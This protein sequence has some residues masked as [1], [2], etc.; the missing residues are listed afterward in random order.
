[1]ISLHEG[2][3]VTFFI[4]KKV[5]MV[6]PT[7]LIQVLQLTNQNLVAQK[8]RLFSSSFAWFPYLLARLFAFQVLFLEVDSTHESCHCVKQI[9]LAARTVLS[10][11]VVPIRSDFSR[12]ART[13]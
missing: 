7:F 3:R 10:D 8:T 5:T 9:C 1:M 6:R 11:R 12:A 2:I 4:A 13:I